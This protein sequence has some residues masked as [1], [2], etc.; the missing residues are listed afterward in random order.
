[1]HSALYTGLVRHRR[2]RPR[3]HAF[4]YRLFMLYIDL[5][6]VDVLFRG[7]LLWSAH[8]PALA[9]WRRA[10]FLGD[11]AVPLREAICELVQR[12]SGTRPT[13]PIRMLTHLRYFGYSF[14]PVTFY[15]CFDSTGTRVDT[16]V[17]EITN[18]PWK[19]RHAYVLSE[20][21]NL[22]R[23][24][25]KR[26]QFDKGFHVSPFIDMSVSYDW[27][28][29]PPGERLAVHMRDLQNGHA[30]FDATLRLTRRPLTSAQMAMSLA[31]FPFMT[32]KVIGAIYWQALQL[33]WKGTPL[34]DH[35][36]HRPPASIAQEEISR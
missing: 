1:M 30:L 2:F 29:T 9:W 21:R 17:A 10:D 20:R 4:A 35:P 34:Y 31:L 15:Y 6:E 22:G 27:R 32:L 3:A 7:R 33:W 24:A 28:F 26:Y 8:R 11:P 14:N 36:K 5:D 13:G 23:G 16:I 19:E 18:T 12:E 25:L